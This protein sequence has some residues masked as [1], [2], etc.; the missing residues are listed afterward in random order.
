MTRTVRK[1]FAYITHSD[2]LLVFRHPNNPE[3]GIQVPAGT[4]EDGE[5]PEEAV[6]REAEEESGLGGLTLL[7]SL[8]VVLFDRRPDL[9]ELHERHFFH[10][11][12]AGDVAETWRHFETHASDGSPPIPFDFFWVDLPGGVP[13]L[14]AQHDACLP[15][16]LASLRSQAGLAAEV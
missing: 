7:S 8:G 3:A 9:D 10:L 6:M 1:A 12:C 15:Q 16:L 11:L 5:T 14:V 13:P 4:M 2:R